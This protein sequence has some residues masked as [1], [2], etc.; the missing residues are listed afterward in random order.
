MMDR[1]ELEELRRIGNPLGDL[2]IT[3]DEAVE[4]KDRILNETNRRD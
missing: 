3:H 2:F 4:M 1:Q